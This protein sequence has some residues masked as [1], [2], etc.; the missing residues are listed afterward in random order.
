MAENVSISFQQLAETVPVCLSLLDAGR[1]LVWGNKAWQEYTGG[2]CQ[3]PQQATFAVHPDDKDQLEK[4]IA[5]IYTRPRRLT[6]EFRYR[7]H[8]GQYR[9]F[10]LVAEPCL[11]EERVSGLVCALFDIT[12]QLMIEEQMLTLNDSLEEIV[13]ER[14]RDLQQANQE[15]K[16]AQSQMLHHEKMASIGQLA[17]GVA[18]EINNPMGFIASNLNSLGKYLDKFIGFIRFQEQLSRV[19]LDQE[20]QQLIATEWRRMKIDYLLN[21]C[22]DLIGESLDGAKRVQEIVSNLKSFSRV[23]RADEQQA[24][25]NECL[26]STI[27]IAWN[28]LK[29]KVT[30]EKEYGELPPLRCHPQ[31]LNQ[32]F[33][34]LLVNAAQAIA[35]KG[36]IKIKTW[37]NQQMIFVEISDTG[38]GIPEENLLRI[39]E[40]F[41][42]T[43]EVGK[44]TGLGMSICY[45]IVNAHGGQIEV[46]SKVGEGSRFTI[47]LPFVSGIA[48]GE[49]AAHG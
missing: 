14:T 23:D 21:D 27:A 41:F 1:Q 38:C 37:H 49:G 25:L 30:L 17:A 48:G 47:C 15:L 40:P 26:E 44:G 42:T 28:E 24:D 8:D 19:H 39:F 33:M 45:D 12:D 4:T 16:Q 34:N 13:A 10:Q 9:S 43:K 7:R 31:Q 22:K 3:D 11:Q 29:Y 6:K 5:Q 32:V 2:S 46:Q 35:E 20:G 18:H 36:V